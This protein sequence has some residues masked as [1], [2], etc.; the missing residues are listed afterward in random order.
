[1]DTPPFLA[2]LRWTRRRTATYRSLMSVWRSGLLQLETYIIVLGVATL[3]SV[4]TTHIERSCKPVSFR[5]VTLTRG[6]HIT[7]LIH[8]I[9]FHYDDIEFE[10]LTSPR[11]VSP[12]SSPNEIKISSNAIK[13]ST[14][15]VKF[16]ER[17]T[18]QY[19]F[20]LPPFSFIHWSSSSFFF[21][22]F[23]VV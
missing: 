17:R 2:T 9:T 6:Q 22:F 1:M 7:S 23:Q 10:Q 18:P 13:Y 21:F 4:Y 11:V 19:S 5:V 3:F 14:L 12:H 20:P 8:L 15:H 16:N